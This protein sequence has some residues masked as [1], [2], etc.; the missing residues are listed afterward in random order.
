MLTNEKNR[1]FPASAP[2]A[3]SLPLVAPFWELAGTISGTIVGTAGRAVT[4]RL[5]YT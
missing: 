5:S 1:C 2:Q 4:P 3:Q